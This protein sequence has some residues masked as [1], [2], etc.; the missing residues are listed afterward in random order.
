MG[1]TEHTIYCDSSTYRP[2]TEL[3]N[4]G[5]SLSLREYNPILASS[6]RISAPIFDTRFFFRRYITLDPRC[7]C[8]FHFFFPIHPF[9]TSTAST[10]AE[11]GERFP[12]NG[13]RW[14]SRHLGAAANAL[15]IRLHF[16]AVSI[17][18]LTHLERHL[19]PSSPTSPRD[20]VGRIRNCTPLVQA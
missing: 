13:E 18:W 15:R 7:W 1:Y 8:A 9:K 6:R 12:A 11:T 16:P 20:L 4:L 14:R 5:T 10:A 3:T 17:E 2:S 19:L